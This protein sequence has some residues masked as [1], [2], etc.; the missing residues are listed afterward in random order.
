[1]RS[2]ESQA[3]RSGERYLQ[4]FEKLEMGKI[5]L[6]PSPSFFER[7]SKKLLTNY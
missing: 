2:V 5:G 1:M 7:T 3:S 6:L 4:A